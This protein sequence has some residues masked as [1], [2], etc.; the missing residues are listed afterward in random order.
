M[1]LSLSDSA[2]ET[3]FEENAILVFNEDFS[4][5]FLFL[6]KALGWA[7]GGPLYFC[8]KTSVVEDRSKCASDLGYQPNLFS[9]ENSFKGEEETTSRDN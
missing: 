2:F 5:R 1:N 3:Q 4:R 7:R 9:I 8:W 6:L